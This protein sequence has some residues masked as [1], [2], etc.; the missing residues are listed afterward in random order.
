MR[1]VMHIGIRKTGTKAIQ[2]FLA[3]EAG[4][5]PHARLCFPTHGRE[6]IWHEPLELALRE[7]D[8]SEL[9]AAVAAHASHG[10]S[11]GVFSGEGLHALPPR[12]IRLIREKLGETQIVMFIRRQ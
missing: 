9:E 3:N 1:W 6:A 7:G 10:D 2:G 11:I 4:H 5:G 8:G 12:S